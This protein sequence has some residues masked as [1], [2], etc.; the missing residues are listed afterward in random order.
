MPRDTNR[1]APPLAER[2]FRLRKWASNS[3]ELMARFSRDAVL[4]EEFTGREADELKVLG[5]KYDRAR[6]RFR[7]E[8]PK[9]RVIT[10]RLTKREIQ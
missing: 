4:V 6:D 7:L 2:S 3:S 10:V 9:E 8:K 1:L 5:I